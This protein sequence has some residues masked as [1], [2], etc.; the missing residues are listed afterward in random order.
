[1][2]AAR[3]TG[4]GIARFNASCLFW[5]KKLAVFSV[6]RRF[7]NCYGFFLVFEI[8]NFRQNKLNSSVTVDD[9]VVLL[10]YFQGSRQR[11]SRMRTS[12][13]VVAWQLLAVPLHG[14]GRPD[15]GSTYEFYLD[16]IEVCLDI[17]LSHVLLLMFVGWIVN[18]KPN[19]PNQSNVWLH[20]IA[21]LLF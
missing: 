17:A 2:P 11:H 5:R 16:F 10:C 19:A 1:V 21:L 8:L 9:S 6:P 15:S 3:G 12:W 7:C 14:R 20:L 4:E 18:S 13:C